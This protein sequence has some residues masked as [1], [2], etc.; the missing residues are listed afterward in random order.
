MN[1]NALRF[2]KYWR[3]S[4]VDA[5]QVKGGLSENDFQKMF[6]ETPFFELPCSELVP[7]CVWEDVINSLFRNEPDQ[8]MTVEVTLMPRVYKAILEHGQASQGR[9]PAYVIPIVSHAKIN[10]SGQIF[11]FLTTIPRDI[12]EPLASGFFALGSLGDVDKFLTSNSFHGVEPPEDGSRLEDGLFKE[13][14]SNY[15]AYAG[16]LLEEVGQGWP[17][18]EDCYQLSDKYYLFKK[19]KVTGAAQHIIKLYDHMQESRPFS[20]LFER[21]AEMTSPAL[22]DCLSSSA[23]FVERLGHASDQHSLAAAQRDA[24]THLMV[25]NHGNILAVNGPPGTGKTTLLLSVVATLWAKAALAG[26]E[27]PVIVASSTNNQAVTNIIDAFG[28]DFSVGK[29]VFAGRWLPKIKSFGA[30]LPSSKKEAEVADT[31]Q[32]SSFFEGLESHEYLEQA[33]QFFLEKATAAFPDEASL[34]IQRAVQLLQQKIQNSSNDLRNIESAWDALLKAKGA[35]RDELGLEPERRLNECR[36]KIANFE[37]RRNNYNSCSNSLVRYLTRESIF[38]ALFNWLPPVAYKRSL[39]AKLHIKEGFLGDSILS[40]D[41]LTE[42]D[43]WRSI[44]EV[45]AGLFKW[46]ST[47][48]DLLLQQQALVKRGEQLIADMEH[49]LSKWASTLGVLGLSLDKAKNSNLD[50]CDAL[51]DTAIRFPIFLLTTHYWEGRWLLELEDTLK[52]IIQSRKNGR[53]AHEARWHRWMKLTP[54]VVSTFFMLP[55]RMKVS[56]HDGKGFVDDYLFDFID[57]LIVD[58]AGQVLPEVAGA[59]FSLAKQSLVIGDTLQIEPIWS[60][61]VAVDIGNLANAGL[62]LNEN[63]EQAYEQI[64]LTGKSVSSGSVMKIAQMSSRY[65]YEKDLE[66]GMF[67]FEH[68]RCYDSIIDYCNKLCYHDKL[69]AKRGEKPTG[70]L[71]GIGYLHIDGLCQKGGGSRCNTHEASVIAAWLKENQGILEEQYG[72]KLNEIVGVITPFGAQKHAIEEACNGYGIKTGKSNGELTVGTVHSF[73]GAERNVIIF[74][75]VYSKHADG[76][77]IDQRDSMLN[78]AVS[79]AKDSF[80]VFGDMDVFSGVEHSKPRG[81]LAQY[82]FRDSAS[83]LRFDRKPREDLPTADSGL[84]YLREAAQHDE[85]LLK[86]LADSKKEVHIVTPWLLL[87]RIKEVGAW[88]AMIAAIARGVK[89]YVYTDK[90]LN[91]NRTPISSN[92]DHGQCKIMFAVKALQDQGVEASL[93]SK[94]H[95]KIIMADDELI[96]I[97]SF[98]WFSA[99]RTG[100]YVRHETSMVYRGYGVGKEIEVVLRSLN[101]RKLR[102]HNS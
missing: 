98:N 79:R 74:S 19:N 82:L 61:P 77:F 35:L 5:D 4:L 83:E 91:S 63:E 45:E 13:Q 94:I 32:T 47:A 36:Q 37:V 33:R 34:T 56:K 17:N 58:E 87:D 25:A 43:S 18:L 71:P 66:R 84:S 59:S 97:G 93:L 41:E 22:E 62:L 68:R 48:S 67:L 54:C 51:A 96:C 60:V 73:Q 40:E 90:E 10:R 7:G 88:E 44:S 39:M 64:S 42:L 11:P 3:N 81:L 52:E 31:Y 55:T 30:Y 102:S 1:D 75:P 99:S 26:G 49:S 46:C 80:L 89:V 12:L 101:Q 92:E 28:K 70:G 14:W 69:I 50:E 78:V 86:T 9:S 6:E 38:Y 53:R 2:A 16:Q 85:F 95:S 15:L 23:G 29:G 65:H 27:P 8:V 20:P 76:G 21:Y 57:L 100:S 72:K 24:L